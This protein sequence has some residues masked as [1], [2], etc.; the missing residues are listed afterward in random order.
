[1]DNQSISM[2]AIED[3]A[4]HLATEPI[5]MGNQEYLEIRLEEL[6]EKYSQ[7][8]LSGLPTHALENEWEDLQFDFVTLEMQFP[9]KESRELDDYIYR[10]NKGNNYRGLSRLTTDQRRLIR[11][12]KARLRRNIGREYTEAEERE[13]SQRLITRFS[14]WLNE[15]VDNATPLLNINL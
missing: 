5:E 9:D 11:D 2:G 4:P 13:Q 1:M 14:S 6:K 8:E 10:I 3:E 15:F 7:K 12:T